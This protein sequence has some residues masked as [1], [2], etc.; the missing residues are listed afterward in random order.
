[1][2]RMKCLALLAIV[3]AA[4]LAG[5]GGISPS[6]Y[7]SRHIAFPL[8]SCTE[9]RLE[10]ARKAYASQ[11]AV[12]LDPG[13]VCVTRTRA[14]MEEDDR[15]AMQGVKPA[16]DAA[17][18]EAGS[19]INVTGTEAAD[20]AALRLEAQAYSS[21]DEIELRKEIEMPYLA[22]DPR[23][24]GVALS[25]GGTKA[26]AFGMGVLAGLADAGL[27]DSASYI[28]SVSG[29]SYAAYFYYT[30]KILPL[31]RGIAGGVPS[32]IDMFRDCVRYPGNRQGE[33]SPSD[34]AGAS[35]DVL[36]RLD[37]FGGCTITQVT[38]SRDDIEAAK[39]VRYQ[40]LVRCQQDV[41][42]PGYC[43]L[44][45]TSQDFGI[46]GSAVLVNILTAVPSW[47]STTIFD[48]G[49]V[50]SP[51]STTYRDGIGMT[52][53]SSPTGLKPLM[54]VGEAGRVP[55]VG[56]WH[57]PDEL[58][59]YENSD[60]V[61]PVVCDP[62]DGGADPHAYARDCRS[63]DATQSAAPV[64]MNFEE[65]RQGLVKARESGHPLPFWIINAV[66]PQNR[67]SLGWWTVAGKYNTTSS[68]V[69]EMTAVSHGSGRYGYVPTSMGFHGLTVLDAV[70]VSAAFL[71]PNQNAVGGKYWRGAIGVA[72]RFGN[73][74]WGKDISNYNVSDGRR[75][76]HTA[77]PFPF[78][79]GLYSRNITH[80]NQPEEDKE[81]IGSV[82]IRLIDGGNGEN[83]G[84]YALLKRGVR[85]IVV[86]D[87][88]HDDGGTFEDICEAR[89]RL[90]YAG[91]QLYVPGLRQLAAH[92]DALEKGETH[93]YGLH[94]W[95]FDFPVLLGCV[96]KKEAGR[97]EDG[98]ACT[99]LDAS[100]SRLFI[101]KPAVNVTAFRKNL[102]NYRSGKNELRARIRAC[103]LPGAAHTQPEALNCE[104][105]IFLLEN[106]DPARG[107]CQVFP[108]HSTVTDTANSSHLIFAA[109]RELGRQYTEAA[110]GL[111]RRL[112]DQEEA[113][114]KEF[115]AI[116]MAQFAHGLVPDDSSCDAPKPSRFHLAALASGSDD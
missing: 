18:L 110:G 15:L 92:C 7:E 88:G 33:G 78:W 109:Y 44:D 24:L 10:A 1:M 4:T 13:W 101:V 36:R 77:M 9:Q 43:S 22:D 105:A 52:Y 113:A 35:P 5:C 112:A 81:R 104:S 16:D 47:F 67:S 76:L 2:T 48:W 116:G 14:R 27:L 42:N 56:S 51:S 70:G 50:T 73:F 96:R 107:H 72:Q 3:G 30:H 19:G 37:E 6:T 100:D 68:D 45:R 97:P 65:F 12:Q 41:L 89:R 74:D 34:D 114:V 91:R 61:M 84:A 63:Q 69:F 62:V 87:A 106:W 108:Q 94:E 55:P 75:T 40:A 99:G 53:G 90:G 93:T 71:D 23:R 26:A 80:R 32:S 8:P 60:L 103:T 20:D 115:D 57:P 28:S 17:H 64:D 21:S 58:R 66:A 111:I 82:F 83:L 31:S 29:G 49:L 25:G 86:S 11:D 95:P 98:A 79:D 54:Q 38:P 46:S 102:E 39:K 85:N 59:R